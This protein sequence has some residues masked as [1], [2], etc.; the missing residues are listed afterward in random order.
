MIDSGLKTKA[1]LNT[2]CPKTLDFSACS[3]LRTELQKEVKMQECYFGLVIDV[4]SR[5]N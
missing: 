1:L 4:N 3:L 2:G 5:Q